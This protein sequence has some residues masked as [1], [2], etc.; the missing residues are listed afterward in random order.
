[1]V[2][3]F[4]IV[5]STAGENDSLHYEFI[6]IKIKSS[7]TDKKEYA[8]EIE[9]AETLAEAGIYSEAVEIL[10]KFVLQAKSQA[11]SG[12]GEKEKNFSAIWTVF[13]GYNYNKDIDLNIKTT[14]QKDSVARIKT[15]FLGNGLL[16]KNKFKNPFVSLMRNDIYISNLVYA[17]L[18]G[19]EGF[20]FDSIFKLENE[21]WMEK[22]LSKK[23]NNEWEFLAFEKDSTDLIS[24]IFKAELH[25]SNPQK[26]L[27]F[28]IPGKY[29][30]ENF[31]RNTLYYKSKNNLSTNPLF[32]FRPASGNMILSVNCFME[33]YNYYGD[34]INTRDT[35]IGPV[36]ASDT[37]LMFIPVN[38]YD[39]FL[40]QPELS[41]SLFLRK[42]TME[43]RGYI[44]SECFFNI[45]NPLAREIIINPEDSTQSILLEDNGNAK[46]NIQKEVE[47][48]F[49]FGIRKWL[50]ARFKTKVL[51][52]ESKYNF[53]KP[54]SIAI[55]PIEKIKF[56]KE[57]SIRGSDLII[58]P[59]LEFKLPPSV[60]ITAGIIWNKRDAPIY[61]NI[62]A[63]TIYL[64]ETYNAVEPLLA[65]TVNHKILYF[66]ISEAFRYEDVK[67][68]RAYLDEAKNGARL[69]S[70]SGK[71][72][73]K[74]DITMLFSENFYLY[75]MGNWEPK[76]YSP[77][78]Y[79]PKT[80][81][82]QHNL[83]I[84]IGMQLKF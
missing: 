68:D 40:S 65:V 79:I 74:W 45:G 67:E 37:L 73:T 57:Y 7:E 26:T 58:N 72:I 71:W 30:W 18:F 70:T 66:K 14:V 33:L 51:F 69:L 60:K 44:N 49:S 75:L 56:N 77:R 38:V 19:L 13:S 76:R 42:F 53:P 62:N 6:I 9:T 50:T 24:N 21:F 55:N 2:F 63:D 12:T 1:M 41:F 59:I 23:Y 11:A 29:T 20:Y 64:W 83:N 43:L 28:S 17:W 78:S 16:L 39:M 47:A 52:G 84:N 48:K 15:F 54:D 34:D 81:E 32:E 80:E 22:V 10:E 25:F 46:I 8:S 27:L 36:G 3:V 61:R 4:G 31:R 35:V 82:V 5:N